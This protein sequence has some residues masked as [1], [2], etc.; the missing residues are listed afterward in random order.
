VAQILSQVEHIVVVMLENRSFDT[1][2]GWLYANGAPQPSQYL[3]N[4]KPFDGLNH[5]LWN[6]TNPAFFTGDPPEKLGVMDSATST[7]NPNPDPL[8]DF[9]NVTQQLYGPGQLASENPQF[10]NLGFVVNYLGPA[11]G[12]SPVEIME[13][14]STAQL[15]V[16]SSLAA[17][18]AVSDAWF[19]SVPS[20]TW[21][22]RS[23]VHAG[24]SNGN[25]VNGDPPNPFDWN[26]K[27]I[28]EVLEKMGVSWK[29]YSDTLLTPALTWLMFPNLAIY[30]LDRFAHFDDFKKACADGALPKYS[31]IEPSF[32]D[33]PND[34]HPPHDVVAGE[35]FV[36]QIW[37]AVSQSPKWEQTLLII[38][39]DEHGGT[40]DHVMPPWGAVCP[41]A[42]SNP[43]KEGFAFN[44]FGVRVPTIVVSPWIQAGTV[45]RTASGT[46]YDHTS[47]LATL[48][49]W[50]GIPANTM[51]GSQRIAAAPSLAQLFTLP[52]ARDVIPLIS[53]PP[54]ETQETSTF[55]P[56]NHL[57]NSLVA[58]Q[59]ARSRMDAQQTLNSIK[60]RQQA[61]D[62]FRRQGPPPQ[63]KAVAI[64]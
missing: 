9:D 17:N 37:Q 26:V 2:L 62:F 29:I 46:P 6:P 32:L 45:F 16:L 44:R 28:Y 59:A 15:P 11:N 1:M 58:A 41:D 35:Q 39:F 57:Q 18:F 36:Y 25:V 33:H 51:L 49:D 19:C 24:T 4:P 27:T 56:P 34:Y 12:N 50:L 5:D 14:Y 60:T 20:D 48:R 47:I 55:L 31:F 64:P 38:T 13:P 42:Q 52:A 21:P 10:P 54:A 63:A 22:N 40:Y 30:S 23:F 53:P 3:R 43:G 8:E 61:I 7:V